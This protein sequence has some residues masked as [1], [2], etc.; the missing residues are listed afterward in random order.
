[1][2]RRHTRRKT[3]RSGLEGLRSRGLETESPDAAMVAPLVERFGADPGESLAVVYLLGRVRDAASVQALKSLEGRAGNREIRR[4]IRRSLFK[5]AQ[6]GLVAAGSGESEAGTAGVRFRLAPE[7]EGYLSPVTSGGLR[8]V[9]LARPQPG[10]LWVMRASVSDRRGLQ[11]FSGNLLR[12]G[13]LRQL[14]EE[15]K[16]R[17]GVSMTPVPWEY[18]D[19]LM[20]DAW[21]KVADSPAEGVADYPRLRTRL[22]A[23]RPV[24]R[25]HPVFDRVDADT[26]DATGL[27]ETPEKLL[28][29]TGLLSWSVERDLMEPFM[30]RLEGIEQSR[31][32]LNP[33]QKEERF[34]SIVRGVVQDLFLDPELR[35]IFAGRFEDAALHLQVSGEEEKARAV[36]GIALAIRRGDLGS[37]GVPLLEAMV[38]RSFVLYKGWQD[39]KKADEEP[40]LIVKP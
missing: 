21:G 5:L 34:R 10:G 30:E 1:M 23:A 4:E 13:E 32:V 15:F 3:I 17:L 39:E 33:M 37:L 27:S 9:I 28:E 12:R 18:A 8:L 11:L 24:P 29:E 38:M 31:I 20:H 7:I 25:A 26:I 6:E 2:D 40:S 22:T 19:W 35:P 36:L 16:A 14:M